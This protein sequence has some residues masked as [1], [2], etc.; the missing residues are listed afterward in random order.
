MNGKNEVKSE[1]SS[2]AGNLAP[3]AQAIIAQT[4]V[5][6]PALNE[7]AALP[8]VLHN[9]RGLG[10]NWIRVVD[11]GSTDRTA[12]VAREHRAEVLSEPFRGYGAA[13]WRGMQELHPEIGW[14]LFCDAD[15]SDDLSELPRLFEAAAAGTELILGDRRATIEGRQAMTPQQNFGNAL[16]TSL[17]ALGWR[18]RYRDLGP[19]R[20]I[21]RSALDRIAM[22]DRGFGWT[23]EMQVRAIEE[24]VRAVEIPV[25]YRRRQAGRSKISGT[26]IG[27][28]RAGS[29]IL[30]TL[31]KLWVCHQFQAARSTPQSS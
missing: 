22:R 20:L 19:L 15:G 10:L 3:V 6:I 25:G 29:V 1:L 16:A 26:L 11:N 8:D 18:H 14:I 24:G 28:L 4:A 21:S 17:I 5:I 31:G 7:E 9:L 2:S 30:S 12:A 13:C 23:V 27:S